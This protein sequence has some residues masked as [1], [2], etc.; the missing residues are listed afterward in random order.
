MALQSCHP[1]KGYDVSQ[2]A[3]DCQQAEHGEFAKTCAKQG[4]FFKCCIR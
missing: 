4:G 1:I 2:C 3:Q